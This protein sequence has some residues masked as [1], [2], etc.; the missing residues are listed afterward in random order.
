MLTARLFRRSSAAGL[1]ALVI[2]AAPLAAGAELIRLESGLSI[3]L[4]T[5]PAVTVTIPTNSGDWLRQG[6]DGTVVLHAASNEAVLLVTTAAGEELEGGGIFSISAT[7]DCAVFDPE[8]G[9]FGSCTST[10]EKL[11]LSLHGEAVDVGGNPYSVV[12]R[13]LFKDGE[14]RKVLTEAV[15]AD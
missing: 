1:L 12:A 10:G 8:A 4:N 11:N 9:V 6:P 14:V 7:F 3:N 2:A 5:V 15:P 13:W